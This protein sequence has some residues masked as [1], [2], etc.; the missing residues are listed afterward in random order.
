LKDKQFQKDNGITSC[1]FEILPTLFP[2]P[3]PS[4]DD[5]KLKSLNE[6]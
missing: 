4:E 3:P 2:P 6:W 1:G 5:L